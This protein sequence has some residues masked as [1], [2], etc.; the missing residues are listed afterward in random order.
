MC[1]WLSSVKQVMYLYLISQPDLG[2]L[3]NHSFC[4]C[5]IE[6]NACMCSDGPSVI[7]RLSVL[8]ARSPS[9]Q[10]AAPWLA[11]FPT[12]ST[13]FSGCRTPSSSCTL[14][15]RSAHCMCRAWKRSWM[16]QV[17]FVLVLPGQVSVVSVVSLCR[18]H[19]G[20][21]TRTETDPLR[22]KEC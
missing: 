6:T 14:S 7:L 2:R 22:W 3:T 5:P 17:G 11:C 10:P 13:F 16:S 8:V 9:P 19:V 18:L 4:Q 20:L 12:C 21:A 15:S 1:V